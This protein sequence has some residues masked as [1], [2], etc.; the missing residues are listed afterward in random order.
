[1]PDFLQALWA[2]LAAYEDM[3]IWLGAG[4]ALLFFGTLLAMPWLAALIPADYFSHERE[5]GAQR[6]RIHPILRIVFHAARNLFGLLL[7]LAGIL[8]LFLP[9]QGLL[10]ILLGI[11]VMRFP[12]KYRFE[13]WLVSRPGILTALNWL[14]AKR[15]IHALT[16]PTPR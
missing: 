13:Q 5:P 12:G 10:T 4:S 6:L 15:N 16:P 3:W 1:M 8:M 14:R 7:V 2:E 9:G 11:L